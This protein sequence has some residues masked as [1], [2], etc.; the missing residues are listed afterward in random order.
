MSRKRIDIDLSVNL[1]AKNA[2]QNL[3]D[4]KNNLASLSTLSNMPI[5]SKITAELSS[6][7]HA[8]G[9]L[10]LMLEQA[11]N[12]NT[13]KLNLRTF[14][15]SLR[16]SG[17]TLLDVQKQLQ[18]L[19]PE[20]NQAFA[21]LANS[22][23]NANSSISTGS[24]LLEKFKK[25][26]SN[27]LTWNISSTIFNAITSSLRDSV[28][29]AKD[30][31]QSLTDIRIVSDKGLG[32]MAKF[33]KE[34]GK[35]AK[36]L[37][38]T[39]KEY[40]DASLIFFQQGLSDE[41]V[42]ERTKVVTKMA[43][44]TGESASD[45]S[46]YMT[47]IWNNFSNGSD[48]LENYADKI[49]A[50]GAATAASSEEIAAGMKQF[51][52]VANTVGL[53]YD[54][55]A[56]AVATVVSETQQSA[57]TVGTAFKTI[58]G[59]LE[60]L[61]L[62]DSLDDGVTLTKYSQAL[63]AVGV[64]ILDQNNELKKMDVILQELG[65]KWDTIS[66]EQQVAL[67]QTVGG[68]RQYNNFL[69]LMDNWDTFEINLEISQGSEGTLA[70]QH[71]KFEQGMEG[72]LNR[73]ETAKENFFDNLI[74]DDFMIDIIDFLAEAIEFVDNLVDNL[75]GVKGVILII[76]NI[77]LR[78]YKQNF[79]KFLGNLG[80]GLKS[81]IP[82]MNLLQ[83]KREEHLKTEAQIASLEAAGF[84]K[85][86]AEYSRL[87]ALSL[88]R[89]NIGRE[90]TADEQDYIQSIIDR[91]TY[92][93]KQ[94]LLQKEELKIAQK[95]VEA[96]NEEIQLLIKK[97]QLTELNNKKTKVAEIQQLEDDYKIA[98]QDMIDYGDTYK[99]RE[100]I[101]GIQ[102][103]LS[104]LPEDG[105]LTTSFE[106]LKLL[107]TKLMD[108][109]TDSTV[110]ET[111]GA[112]LSKAEETIK[113]DPTSDKAQETYFDLLE[114]TE[115]FATLIDVDLGES[116]EKLEARIK[117][118][119][120]GLGTLG[121][122]IQADTLLEGLRHDSTR[123]M[124]IN[125]GNTLMDNAVGKK[126]EEIIGDDMDLYDQIDK[127]D[128]DLKQVNQGFDQQIEEIE[129]SDTEID[130]I[131]YIEHI[132]NIEACQEA[133]KELSE[134]AEATGQEL[135]FDETD[136]KLL[137]EE[138]EAVE[139][140]IHVLDQL[141]LE[142]ETAEEKLEFENIKGKLETGEEISSEEANKV[143]NATNK[144]MPGVGEIVKEDFQT[145]KKAPKK[146][147]D[148][149]KDKKQIEAL[150]A[151]YKKLAKTLGITEKEQ[152][153]LNKLFNKLKKEG[154]NIRPVEREFQ[155]LLKTTKASEKELEKLKKILKKSMNDEEI[156][157]LFQSLSQVN[158]EL[159]EAE[160]NF[161]NL[162]DAA[163]KAG[164]EGSEALDK[165]GQTNLSE[166][167][168]NIGTAV[169]NVA[170]A[171][172]AAQSLGSIWTDEDLTTGEKLMQTMMAMS[173]ILPVVTMLTNAYD[174]AK[175]AKTLST[176]K[177]TIAELTKNAA[178]MGGVASTPAKIAADKAKDVST[179]TSTGVQWAN[180]LAIMANPWMLGIALAAL[181][182]AVVAIAAVSAA[183]AKDTKAQEA[184]NKADDE[185]ISK[186][187]DKTEKIKEEAEALIEASKAL[188]DNIDA[189]EDGEGTIED[190][191]DAIKELSDSTTA[192]RENQE[193]QCLTLEQLTNNYDAVINKVKELAVEQLRAQQQQAQAELNSSTKTAQR[194]LNS[195]A[196]SMKQEGAS[197]WWGVLG[198]ALGGAGG[199]AGAMALAN[200]IQMIDE[201]GWYDLDW[202]KYSYIDL[203]GQGIVSNLPENPTAEQMVQYYDELEDVLLQAQGA[204][205]SDDSEIYS[206]VEQY[207][208]DNEETINNLRAQAEETKKINRSTAIE[209]AAVETGSL[210]SFASQA[211]FYQKVR[212]SQE[213]AGVSDAE[214]KG[215]LSDYN[216]GALYNA[217]SIY[218][219]IGTSEFETIDDF[220]NFLDTLSAT[221]KEAFKSLTSDQIAGITNYDQLLEAIDAQRVK[222]AKSNYE[223]A[224]EELG[225][226]QEEGGALVK[227]IKKNDI[228][229]SIFGDN[230]EAIY[231]VA[232]AQLESNSALKEGISVW[233]ENRQAILAGTSNA[234]EYATAIGEVQ[235]SIEK[236]AG[237]ELSDEFFTDTNN[238]QWIDEIFHGNFEN[239]GKLYSSM[240]QDYAQQV[241]FSSE[242]FSEEVANA[243]YGTDLNSSEQGQQ[244]AEELLQAVNN[245]TITTTEAE[246][247]LRAYGYAGSITATDNGQ[248]AIEATKAYDETTFAQADFLEGIEIDQLEIEEKK[249]DKIAI[250]LN[251]ISEAKDRAFGAAKLALLEAEK[252]KLDELKNA[253]EEYLQK[254][255]EIAA[256]KV[257]DLASKYNYDFGDDNYISPEEELA[258]RE[259]YKY[260]QEAIDALDAALDAQ[261]AVDEANEELDETIQTI[262]D[263][264]WEN[265]ET[266]LELKVTIN[267]RELARVEHELSKL[268]NTTGKISEKFSLY[269]QKMS[270]TFDSLVIQTEGINTILTNAE[271]RALSEDEANKLL[272][273]QEAVYETEMTLIELRDAALEE[274]STAFEELNGDIEEAKAG[275]DML[276]STLETYS[277]VV[278]TLGKTNLGNFENITS[279][280]QNATLENTKFQIQAEQANLIALNETKESLQARLNDENISEQEVEK[281]QDQIKETENLISE[282]QSNLNSLWETGL[283]AAQEIFTYTVE[284]A[285][286]TMNQA[287]GDIATMTEEFNQQSTL[288]N[289]YLDDYERIYQLSKMS[290]SL[291]QEMDKT[292]S[293]RAKN[294][295]AE[296]MEEINEKTAESVKMSQQD[297][298]VL[299]KKYELRQA[300]IA[301]EEAQNAKSQVRL[302]RDAD[303]GM[304][305]VYTANQSDIDAAQQAYEDKMY[306]LEKMN[307]D[308]IQSVSE[309]WLSA[310]QS[311]MDSLNEIQNDTTLSAEEREAKLQDTIAFYQ[312]QFNYM[313]QEMNKTLDTNKALYEADYLNY[314]EYYSK[315]AD[316]ATQWSETALGTLMTEES[317]N[318]RFATLFGNGN[319]NFGAVGQLLT[320]FSAANTTLTDSINSLTAATYGADTT[321]DTL[322]G[323]ENIRQLL[324]DSEETKNNV[325]Q[326]AQFLTDQYEDSIQTIRSFVT[327]YNEVMKD[328]E[329]TTKESVELVA[330]ELEKYFSGKWTI[331]KEAEAVETTGN[332]TEAGNEHTGMW[333]G[334]LTSAWGPEGKAL[335]VHEK[336]LILN[337][338]QT[339]DMFYLAELA[340]AY[341]RQVEGLGQYQIPDL[342]SIISQIS[343][344]LGAGNQE[345]IVQEITIQ[346]D[347]PG[348][349][350]QIEIEN[351]FSNIINMASQYANRK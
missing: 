133:L 144:S 56:T 55:A 30:L 8:A 99:K 177:E 192:L 235:Q 34:A 129:S 111:L 72:A 165:M 279:R 336:E 290:R 132:N 140:L 264:E 331:T 333:T 159:N 221:D 51:A 332:E 44:V 272:E 209:V 160:N 139:Q 122:N 158:N 261:E 340:Q 179:N 182:I 312:E 200:G 351:A 92:Q 208:D 280:L 98:K 330:T 155:K 211:E 174:K 183:T 239:V 313:S 45:V 115:E 245:K 58:F 306:E 62:G 78:I 196:G 106:S 5:G 29:Y 348:V 166:K 323:E 338:F 131:N 117:D 18:K 147:V 218:N 52:A 258:F 308:Y 109:T 168:T 251:K 284:Q 135:K 262:A 266:E 4:L 316:L 156:E 253:Q 198:F 270:T 108:N 175:K 334:G 123:T 307:D 53:T 193:L 224:V 27:V 1:S 119:I 40:V 54:Y 37:S 326:A 149:T 120:N 225:L 100:N 127:P 63:D 26:F 67:A 214:L 16:K 7:S 17:L 324:L 237:V 154:G 93:E 292:D 128:S 189:Y 64:K 79:A 163:I 138:T 151:T 337:K 190:V 344:S 47:A 297:L 143:V 15:Q 319:D 265:F 42:E 255:Q 31:N 299:Q 145:V 170:M 113:A 205:I 232:E 249:L 273:Y 97:S 289:Q 173:S 141:I 216:L 13:G 89:R 305:Y 203:Q 3:N 181:A 33:A 61:S 71:E 252:D 207:L 321:I 10:K 220:Y 298:N 185:A 271:G 142:S 186:S 136:G 246:N 73:L 121:D 43:A 286:A 184:K 230:E 39:T 86:T 103:D 259:K 248:L 164:N 118:F 101:Q 124:S 88:Q 311:L 256:N 325:E 242:N 66:T 328:F 25:S 81:L 278:S 105:E 172:Q 269:N 130:M 107:I 87:L 231:K 188:R 148:A 68:M 20:G 195:G 244:L 169:S 263:N 202:S 85:G 318:E 191:Y 19:G 302:R 197:G 46:S 70:E 32:D 49:T 283:T 12:V 229:G 36:S 236:F 95:K 41:Q 309:Q 150:E 257:D 341:I 126:T 83:K 346:A 342:V 14:E 339:E 213:F 228:D 9:Q 137:D 187:K 23:A 116:L 247:I 50:L 212:D 60:S 161:Q 206:S 310:E 167:I 301:L 327:E 80:N 288:D 238:M 77:L 24:V 349:N 217:N 314:N 320:D 335:I 254:A 260:D 345:A 322:F 48:D 125:K 347:F 162:E 304:S 38:T 243:I 112:E 281:F 59:R 317:L 201:A 6:A 199:A 274:L 28:S 102:R 69:A 157:E 153:K 178:E 74:D 35:T 57:D 90:L 146:K 282:S 240:A 303:G 152:S 294:K 227:A 76:S 96:T 222:V 204:G 65:A 194:K 2:A 300:E 277:N 82:G 293:V 295:L 241:G 171:W 268:E 275:F 291:Q 215:E 84:Q 110:K 315:K 329:T 276:T 223:K 285:I 75:G 226:T 343:N 114:T 267:E 176:E 134:I 210:D 180:N 287:L 21:Q 250:E 219:N 22:V 233:E 94:L 234:L 11:T 296:I 350:S 91:Q 104:A